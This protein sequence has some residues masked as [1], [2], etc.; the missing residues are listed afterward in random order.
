M[1]RE[2]AVSAGVMPSQSEFR[3]IVKVFFGRKMAVVGFSI[4]AMWVLIAIFAPHLAPYDPYEPDVR[5]ILLQ[6][7]WEHLLGTDAIGRDTLSRVIYGS[8]IALLVGVVAISIAASIGV[9]LGLIAA[10]FGGITYMVIMRFV[11]TLMSFPMIVKAL[12]LAALTGGGLKSVLIAIS[13]VLMSTYARL[14][15]G[16]V[17]SVKELDYVTAARAIGA[18]N[19][20]IILRH[21]L[22]NSFPPLIVQ[23]T[24]QMGY[25]IL[26]EASLSF[27][28]VGINPPTAAWGAMVA[29]GYSYLFTNPMLSFAPGL[30][31][32][33]V[34]FG[35]NM[36]GDGLRDVL[37]PRLRGSL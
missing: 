36:M 34:V 15:C 37:D 9:T 11:D 33:S 24:L 22:P 2:G 27:L 8:W 1:T 6:P 17:L 19:L 35:F 5:Q 21:I 20:R 7:S 28:G 4:V 12:V 30:A 14:I 29:D 16:L 31:I 10:Y 13:I 25:A 26:L 32:M 3:R 18:G 23:I